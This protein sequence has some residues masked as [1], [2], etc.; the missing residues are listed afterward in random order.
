MLTNENICFG[1]LYVMPPTD[2]HETPGYFLN[3]NYEVYW[4]ETL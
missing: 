1:T 4:L 3:K 2:T